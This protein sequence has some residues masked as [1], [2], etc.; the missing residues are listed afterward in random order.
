[1][2]TIGGGISW[3]KNGG[4]QYSFLQKKNLKIELPHGPTILLSKY[5]KEMISMP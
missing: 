5:S 3:Y 2:Y 1:M 4:K